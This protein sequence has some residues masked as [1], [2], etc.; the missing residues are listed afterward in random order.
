M[1]W[2]VDIIVVEEIIIN[3]LGCMGL[4]GNEVEGGNGTRVFCVGG[5]YNGCLQFPDLDLRAGRYRYQNRILLMI[6]NMK[7]LK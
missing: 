4:K 5:I 3:L 1:E 7:S 6:P 2:K